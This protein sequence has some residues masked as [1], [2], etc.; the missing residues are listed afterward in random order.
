MGQNQIHSDLASEVLTQLKEG[1]YYTREETQFNEIKV[2]TIHILKEGQIYHP[3]GQYIEIS[4]QDY[5]K[6]QDII[7]VLHQ[8]LKSFIINIPRILIV[9]LGNRYLTNDAIGPQTLRDIKITHYL[10]HEDRQRNHYYD[11]LALTPG[12]MYQTGMESSKII[13]SLVKQ[14]NID[15]VIVIDALCASSYE[16]LGHVIQINNAGIYP[17]SGVGNHRLGINKDSIG[18]QVIAIGVPTVIYAGALFKD[19]L[20]YL[21]GYFGDALNPVN[22]LK[23]GKRKQ[24]HGSLSNQQKTQLLG[25]IGL[26]NDQELLNL[27]NEILDPIDANYVLSDKKIDEQNE[28]LS[29]IIAKSINLL[30]Y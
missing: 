24:Y 7:Q 23:V 3:K 8:S 2:E 10:N 20:G 30:T 11:I 28:V 9:G 16:K 17:G 14:E 6:E 19:L 27:F 5:L 26:L 22:K 13:Q 12:V 1:Q 25:D 21:K 18:C 29:R 15:L 4:F